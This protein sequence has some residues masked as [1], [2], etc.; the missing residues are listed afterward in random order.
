MKGECPATTPR[1]RPQ[2]LQIQV[3]NH[4]PTKERKGRAFPE[5]REIRTLRLG[6]RGSKAEDGKIKGRKTAFSSKMSTEPLGQSTLF[7]KASDGW[8][9]A[10]LNHFPESLGQEQ[11]ADQVKVC[12]N[13]IIRKVSSVP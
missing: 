10:D 9:T 13:G 5:D 4:F 6:V 3:L 12:T 1:A 2:N 8:W 11:A 7:P